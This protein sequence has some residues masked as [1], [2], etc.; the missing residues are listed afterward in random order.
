MTREQA[1][2]I[3]TEYVKACRED[4]MLKLEGF[5]YEEVITAMDMGAKALEQSNSLS[6]LID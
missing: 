3:L 2:S 1:S 4:D 5:S 6:A